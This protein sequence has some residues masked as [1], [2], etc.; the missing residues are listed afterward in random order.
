VVGAKLEED[1]WPCCH[2]WWSTPT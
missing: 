1:L 2:Q